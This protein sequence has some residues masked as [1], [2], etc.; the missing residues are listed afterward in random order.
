MQYT[1][2]TGE[3]VSSYLILLP[4]NYFILSYAI[5]TARWSQ[6]AT[7][8]LTNLSYPKCFKNILGQIRVT[9]KSYIIQA[10]GE[11]TGRR[12]RRM[13][14]GNHRCAW[15]PGYKHWESQRLH[16]RT[17]WYRRTQNLRLR[18]TEKQSTM[19]DITYDVILYS[20]MEAQCL[21][22]KNSWQSL[23]PFPPICGS[24]SL[25]RYSWARDMRRGSRKEEAA[26]MYSEKETR[27]SS[28]HGTSRCWKCTSN[29]SGMR[30]KRRNY[31]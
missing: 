31:D 4:L 15:Q 7:I 6:I 27:Q 2:H 3:S 12:A 21:N 18:Y 19:F 30:L 25:R 14:D 9:T 23:S 22:G 16:Q 13:D 5:C 24:R 1:S 20:D 8:Y 26:I 28:F 17:G 10:A 11:R 29:L